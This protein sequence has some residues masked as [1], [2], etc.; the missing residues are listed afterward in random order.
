MCTICD[1]DP[2]QQR[3]SRLLEVTAGHPFFNHPVTGEPVFFLYDPPHLLKSLRNALVNHDIEFSDGMVAFWSYIKALWSLDSSK[4]LR[5]VPRLSSKH[6]FLGLGKKM[7][8]KLAA[9]VFSHSVYAGIM[10]YRE[11]GLLPKDSDQT[12]TFV[13]RMNDIW[14]LFNCSRL[15]ATGLKQ[16][17]T[18]G[19][20]VSRLSFLDDASSFINSLR[21]RHRVTEQGAKDHLPSKRGLLI[22]IAA[23]KSLL[24]RL[25]RSGSSCK[26]NF[27][28]GR[29]LNQDCVEN[30]FSQIRR[31]K[32]SFFEMM[33]VWRAI[34]NLRSVAASSYLAPLRKN[35]SNCEGDSDFH[36]IDLFQPNVPKPTGETFEVDS[37]STRE[38]CTSSDIRATSQRSASQVAIQDIWKDNLVDL[39]KDAL[40]ND[41]CEYVAGY[42][43][44]RLFQKFPEVLD[45]SICVL[46]LTDFPVDKTFLSFKC[47]TSNHMGLQTPSEELT[48]VIKFWDRHFKSLF[49]SLCSESSLKKRISDSLLRK[50]FPGFVPNCHKSLI[51]EFCVNMFVKIRIF[52]EIKI[53]NEKIKCNRTASLR[54]LSK[55]CH[56]KRA[57]KK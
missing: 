32:G 1:L 56:V 44:R 51:V 26:L 3:L 43:I 40:E 29:R 23:Y 54:K 22:T 11:H 24:Q 5:L 53:L 9:Q 21:F 2:Q 6:V 42:I 18:P 17:T 13:K 35:N 28:I 34:S 8:V 16:A 12:A 41:A 14:D 46:H 31:D 50:C 25:L 52:R 45:C 39:R 49:Q 36:L 37:S 48:G 10:T 19:N 15:D 47:F 55:L 33:P 27:L 57:F 20:L 30:C 4:S 7:S 38:P